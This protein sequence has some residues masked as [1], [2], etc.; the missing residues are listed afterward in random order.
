M[1]HL[2]ARRR[3]EKEERRRKRSKAPAISREEKR[4]CL[5][6]APFASL[7][8]AQMVGASWSPPQR[9]YG[10]SFCGLWHLTSAPEP[11]DS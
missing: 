8:E 9:P 1:R 5:D 10:C 11:D 6:K 2:E 3:K 7:A 4:A